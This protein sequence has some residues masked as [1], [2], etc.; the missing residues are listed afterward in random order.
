MV[1]ENDRVLEPDALPLVTYAFERAW[2]QLYQSGIVGP[3]NKSRVRR[4]LAE[5]ITYWARLGERDE[6]RLA[7]RAMF[8]VCYFERVVLPQTSATD[9]AAAS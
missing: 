9:M 7:R 2:Q 3:F 8:H 5:Q 1:G 4:M 6:W